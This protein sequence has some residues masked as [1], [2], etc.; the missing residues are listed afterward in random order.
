MCRSTPCQTAQM[1]ASTAAPCCGPQ[2]MTSGRRAARCA[3]CMARWTCSTC[4]ASSQ[5]QHPSRCSSSSDTPAT[6]LTA[7]HF[8]QHARAYNSSLCM[9]STGL[10][11]PQHQQPYTM[12]VQ[13]RV[14]HS[15]G[16]LEER[17]Q[18]TQ[19]MPQFAQLAQLYIIDPSNPS[20]QQ[21]EQRLAALA[22]H[23]TSAG[24]THSAA[25]LPGAAQPVR[26]PVPPGGSDTT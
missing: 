1:S 26:A 5:S 16:P 22:P 15:I 17:G 21:L 20:Q 25:G 14:Y 19:V 8:R 12:F 3:A 2:S 18:D 10:H 7:Q 4:S 23:A 6:A 13:G 24:H 9:A 11:T